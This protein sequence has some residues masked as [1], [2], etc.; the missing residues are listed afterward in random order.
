MD[1]KAPETHKTRLIVEEALPDHAYALAPH[2]RQVDKLEVEC[3]WPGIPVEEALRYGVETSEQAFTVVTPDNK[4]HGLWGHGP[5]GCG[6][7]SGDMGYVWLVSDDI[8]FKHHRKA[9]TRFA[10]DVFFPALDRLYTSG[11]GNLVHSKNSVHLRWLSAL[12]FNA[13][14]RV[15]V[16]GQPFSLMMRQP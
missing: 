12:N 4:L 16:H 9:I 6:P 13:L 3:T 7:A 15:D 11:Y 5:W 8:L 2:L 1:F 14:R 10:R